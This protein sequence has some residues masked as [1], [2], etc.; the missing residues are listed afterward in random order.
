MLNEL[1]NGEVLMQIDGHEFALVYTLTALR[2]YLE[3]PG[4][5]PLICAGSAQIFIKMEFYENGH[6][7]NPKLEKLGYNLT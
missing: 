4:D 7:K 1:Q 3:V 2:Q 6:N 5:E